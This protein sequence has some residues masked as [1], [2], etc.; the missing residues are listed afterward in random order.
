MY[1]PKLYS[2]EDRAKIL[3]FLRQNEFAILVTYDGEKPTAS[4]LLV[5]IV[6]EGERLFINSHMSKA[7]S[8]WKLFEMNEE[9]LVIFYGPHT[10]ISPTWYNH[11]NV[12]TWN[13]QAVHVYGKP[14]IVEEYDEAYRILKRLVDRHEAG[15]HYQME[16][17]PQDF[18]RKEIN[19]VAAFQIEVTRI[20]ANYKLSQNRDDEDYRNIV[21]K[22]DA[23][24]DDMSHGVA[25]AMREKRPLTVDH[26]R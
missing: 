23:R 15:S 14:R 24:E 5:E 7:N 21:A 12:P 4:H 25:E 2:E 3:E 10:Y 11:V 6:E 18:V 16:S 17:L 19:G 8:Q 13:Y 26:G 22:L 20:E 9:V 1:T